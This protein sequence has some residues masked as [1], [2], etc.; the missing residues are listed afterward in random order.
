MEWDYNPPDLD[1][2][3]RFEVSN[4][5]NDNR[6]NYCYTFFGNRKCVSTNYILDNKRRG[7]NGSEIIEVDNVGEY[8]YF[9]YVR[10][11]FDISNNTAIN[12]NKIQDVEDDLENN[13]DINND[14][15]NYYLKNDELLKNS[16]AQLSLYTNGVRLPIF[17]LNIPNDEKKEFKFDYWAGFCLNGKKGLSDLKIINK[18]YINEPPKNICSE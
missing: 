14:I 2:I 6:T 13:K 17:I 16:G 15:F 5:I 3:C 12:E 1:L 10:K 18:F 8:D 4:N 11:Y 9:F 7:K